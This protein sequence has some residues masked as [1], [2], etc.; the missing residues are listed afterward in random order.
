MWDVRTKLIAVVMG[1]L[2]SAPMNLKNNLE[3]IDVEISV[4]MIQKCAL[5]WSARILR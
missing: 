4:K 3:V 5:L 1:A 2:G